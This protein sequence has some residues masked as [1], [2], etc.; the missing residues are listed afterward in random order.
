M[1]QFRVPDSSSSSSEDEL[2]EYER[3][4]AARLKDRSDRRQRLDSPG[5]SD[6]DEATQEQLA[7]HQARQEERQRFFDL[8]M[9]TED[10][11]KCGGCI[12][13]YFAKSWLDLYCCQEFEQI[14]TI[15]QQN[16]L[17]NDNE[18]YKCIVEH[19]A[20]FHQCLYPFLLDNMRHIYSTAGHSGA[21]K[22]DLNEARRY[23]AY[24]QF[25]SWVRGR[26]GYKERRCIPQCATK[27]IRQTFPS[28]KGYR[29]YEEA[30]ESELSDGEQEVDDDPLP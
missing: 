28:E 13:V 21:N 27:K 10:W 16:K 8:R 3:Q 7:E 20:F 26:C 11:C 17:Y 29:G 6:E 18:K 2:A 15:C 23:I 12:P 4:R 19:P 22:K 1:A 5:W 9:T 24:R 30:S 25:T 14:K